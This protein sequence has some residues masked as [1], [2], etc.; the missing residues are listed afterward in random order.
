MLI[1]KIAKKYGEKFRPILLFVP[2]LHLVFWRDSIVMGVIMIVICLPI[3]V[4]FL[5]SIYLGAKKDV[6]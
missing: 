6:D 5:Y 4:L 1:E 2:A 3:A